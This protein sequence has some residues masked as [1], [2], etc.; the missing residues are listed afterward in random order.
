MN[1][2]KNI[3]ELSN[4]FK[5]HNF[6]LYLVGGA[7]R[8]YKLGLN[9]DD[10]DF[11]TDAKP[12]EVMS[13]FPHLSIPTGIK[14]GTVT[15]LFKQASY[16]I[17]TFRTEGDYKDSRHPDTI[18]FTRSLSTDLE[19]RDFTINALAY[20]VENNKIIDL[21]QGNED[22]EAK[23]IRAINN[24]LD[25]FTEDAL[26]MLRACRFAAKL[27][28]TLEEKTFQAIKELKERILLVSSERIREELFKIIESNNPSYGIKLLYN[29][30]LLEYILPELFV[31]IGVEQ[32]GV[33]TQDVFNHSL[34]TLENAKD[35]PFYV[36]VAALF[37]DLGKVETKERKPDGS[38]SYY[39][40][41]TVGEKITSNIL[42]RLKCSNKE[43][44]VISSLVKN[45]MF[46]YDST[47]TDAAI[48]RFIHR[49]GVE[50][51]EYLYQ[52]RRADALAIDPKAE[53]ALLEELISRVNK[54]LEEKTFLLKSDLKINGN[55]L[56]ALGLKGKAIG[57]MIEELF[58]LVIQDPKLNTQESLINL[59]REKL[60]NQA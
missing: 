26:R 42:K 43:I 32:G 48:R 28:F 44:E 40:H 37:H 24:P 55:D 13:M 27:N 57:Q 10:Y 23:L 54:E 30:G 34:T 17:T 1:L 21:H 11:A 52:L 5:I 4:I 38:F 33:H 2:N 35:Y 20:D 39:H 6:N 45:H 3:K 51:L 18:S 58:C 8:D 60:I 7:I 29:T 59:A 47:W 53:L 50:N 46:N 49:V 56:I 19:R 14:H 15:V 12:E 16:E 25:R 41:E 22:L 9:N 36:K 31:T